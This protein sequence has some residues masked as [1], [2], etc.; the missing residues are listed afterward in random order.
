MNH[1]AQAQVARVAG[2]NQATVSRALSGAPCISPETAARVKAA[3][4]QLGYHPDPLLTAV[5]ASRWRDDGKSR[6]LTFGF[7]SQ[8]R[9]ARAGM[10]PE[11][12]EGAE[13]RAAE[14]GCR[15]DH[16]FLE[17]YRNCAVLQRT[18]LARGLRGLIV[19]SFFEENP[20]VMLNWNKF[21]TVSIGMTPYQPP[22]HAVAQDSYDGALVAWR[23]VLDYGYRRPGF[24]ITLHALPT[25][26]EDDEARQSAALFLQQK[27]R[28]P[29]ERI[30]PFFHSVG[31]SYDTQARDFIAWYRRWKPDVV[32]GFN[33]LEMAF[34]SHD[35][36]VRIPDQVGFAALT[37]R[38]TLGI[39]GVKD[40]AQEVGA[41]AVDLLLLTLR[42]NQW[43][44]PTT[45]IR[46]YLEPQWLDGPT[47]PRRQ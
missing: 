31:D 15:L 37:T 4:R 14:T 26:V 47:L 25:H 46:H 43:G 10:D 16:F 22:L 18:L 12:F 5:A 40:A 45:R 38:S 34:L 2:V 28:A 35:A 23:Q 7:I 3:A 27:D 42:T 20:A 6:G 8:F 1:V 9:H 19:A 24:A 29:S 30:P 39:A 44:L 11:N 13:A 36:K 17:D 21:C 33:N 41:A 32:I